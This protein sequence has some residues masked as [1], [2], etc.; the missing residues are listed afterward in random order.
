MAKKAAKRRSVGLAIVAPSDADSRRYRAEEAMRTLI[1]A[2]EH[3]KDPALMRDVK[4]L[5]KKHMAAVEKV[6]K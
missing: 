5:A 1:R 6:T 3:R 4:A 2:A